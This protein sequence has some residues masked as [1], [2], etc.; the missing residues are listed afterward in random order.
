[1]GKKQGKT[2]I[3]V[4]DVPGFYVNRCLGPYLVETA[5]LMADGVPL[6]E[7]DQALKDYGLPVGPITLADEV[8]AA[9]FTAA[10]G[11]RC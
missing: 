10:P 4:K 9:H 6:E 1:V 8:R 3:F 11:A 5:A 2:V 7:L